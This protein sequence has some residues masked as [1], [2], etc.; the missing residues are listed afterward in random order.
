MMRVILAILMGTTITG[1]NSSSSSEWRETSN[2]SYETRFERAKAICNG[3][4]AET[5]IIAGRRWIAGAIA[6]DSSFKG[7]MAEQGF[8]PK[9]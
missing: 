5:Q 8:A 6:S 1:C 3:R 9:N 2:T 7:C 4:A